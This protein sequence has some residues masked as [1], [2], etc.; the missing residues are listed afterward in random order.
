MFS[1]PVPGGRGMNSYGVITEKPGDGWDEFKRA[2]YVMEVRNPEEGVPGLLVNSHADVV[3]KVPNAVWSVTGNA[4]LDP[5][6]LAGQAERQGNM[7]WEWRPGFL[8]R[9]ILIEKNTNL[10][11]R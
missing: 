9:K 6:T 10:S 11:R 7:L 2:L 8:P 5:V 3:G 1:D 4:L